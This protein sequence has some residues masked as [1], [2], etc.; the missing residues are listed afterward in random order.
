MTKPTVYR[1]PRRLNLVTGIMLLAFVAGVYWLWRFGPV[2]LDAWT[3]DHILKE[4]ANRVYKA[5]RLGEP[6]RTEALRTIVDEAKNSIVKRV[7]IQDPELAVNLD[8]TGKQV[9]VTADYHITVL[10]PKT[11]YK[12]EL[13]LRREATANIERVDWGD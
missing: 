7:G 8:L 2:Y 13:H 6:A 1:A 3:V 9:L 5:N 12:T 10:H 11:K 4:A